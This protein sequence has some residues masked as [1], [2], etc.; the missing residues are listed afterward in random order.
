[1]NERLEVNENEFPFAAEMRV[2]AAAGAAFLDKRMEGWADKI[3]RTVKIH[4]CSE[5]ILGQ[6]FGEFDAG[7][8]A[9]SIGNPAEAAKLGFAAPYIMAY[10]SLNAAWEREVAARKAP[11]VM[12]QHREPE[13]VTA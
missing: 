13:L 9:L 10:S 1:V 8:M 5:C 3:T 7:V 4:S 2:L 12:W 6:L 11:A